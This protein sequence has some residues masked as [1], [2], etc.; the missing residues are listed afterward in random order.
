MT[1]RVA[2]QVKFSCSDSLT[3]RQKTGFRVNFFESSDR[4]RALF[5]V[6]GLRGYDSSAYA[7]IVLTADLKSSILDASGAME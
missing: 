2:D 1:Q 4:R 7:A 5:D 3:E 6:V